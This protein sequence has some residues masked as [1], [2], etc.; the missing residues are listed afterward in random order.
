MNGRSEYPLVVRAELAALRG[1]A[2][3]TAAL[4][5]EALER[6]S[7]DPKTEWGPSERYAFDRVRGDPS[8]ANLLHAP[9]LDR[10]PTRPSP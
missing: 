1:D 4:L 2:A 9:A 5:Q 10:R 8:L 3:R 6:N 7:W